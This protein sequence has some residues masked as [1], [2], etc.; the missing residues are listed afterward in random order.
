MFMQDIKI[1]KRVN[2]ESLSRKGHVGDVVHHRLSPS[3]VATSGTFRPRGVHARRSLAN[4]KSVPFSCREDASSE[5]EA[6]HGSLEKRTEKEIQQREQIL[7]SIYR[8]AD[9]VPRETRSLRK[10]QGRYSGS[11]VEQL[12]RPIRRPKTLWRFLFSGSV[13]VVS[14]LV[15]Y[16]VMHQAD[17]I[18]PLLNMWGGNTFVQQ[19]SLP[20]DIY[21]E[22]ISFDPGILYGFRLSDGS[23]YFGMIESVHQDHYALS[24]VFY[25]S[26]FIEGATSSPS[27]T[28]ELQEND[29]TV[30]RLIKVGSEPYAPQDEVYIPRERVQSVS[31][32]KDDS[33]IGKAINTYFSKN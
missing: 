19:P 8:P 14:G 25:H 29:E 32:L 2:T 20:T 33:S 18:V 22:K 16:A 21:E 24:H 7:E 3:S 15:I 4:E 12:D 17:R 11:R 30:F 10:D 31:P 13:I 26:P 5:T 9:F 23:V 1:K 6:A 28:D 27:S